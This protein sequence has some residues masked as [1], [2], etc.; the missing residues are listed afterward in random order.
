M[1]APVPTLT[2]T[3]PTSV[4]VPQEDNIQVSGTVSP[5]VSGATILFKV[6][7]ANGVVTTHSTTTDSTSSYRVKLPP[8]TSSHLGNAKVE[9]FYNGAGKYGNDD[10]SCTV[11]VV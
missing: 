6:T 10:V 8:I 3:C 2:M 5:K 9:A 7:R 1:P 11:P 4:D